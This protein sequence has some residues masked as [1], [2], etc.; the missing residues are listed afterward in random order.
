M[1]AIVEQWGNQTKKVLAMGEE[2]FN[3][4]K[5]VGTHILQAPIIGKEADS[6]WYEPITG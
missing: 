5:R 1:P 3:Q 2:R 6:F 4:R